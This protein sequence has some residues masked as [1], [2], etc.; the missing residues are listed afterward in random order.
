MNTESQPGFRH[1]IA[2][3][4]LCLLLQGCVGVGALKTRTETI[5]DPVVAD[6]AEPCGLSHRDSTGTNDTC[7]TEAWLS[8]HWGKPTC[9]NYSGPDGLDQIW[10]YKFGLIWNGVAPIVL[11]PVPLVLPTGRE[12]VQFFLRD[13]RVIS[14][15]QWHMHSVGG[16]FGC[17]A[18]PCGF[19]FG[20]FSLN[21]D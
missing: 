8:T 9:I 13:G 17:S 19:N 21:D 14:G 11:V 1:A 3:L 6:L 15:R 18:G 20:A 16:A 4:I 2:A 7:Y 12:Q 10:V 5:H